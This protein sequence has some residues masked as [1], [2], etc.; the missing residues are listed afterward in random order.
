MKKLAVAM[1]VLSISASLMAN[2]YQGWFVGGG[3][4][5][6]KFS[7]DDYYTGLDAKGS[8]KILQR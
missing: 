4:N 8:N 7:A 3:L 5:T 2:P 1:L 6:I